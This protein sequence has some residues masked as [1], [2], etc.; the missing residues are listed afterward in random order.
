MEKNRNGKNIKDVLTSIKDKYIG[1]V[2]I[3]SGKLDYVSE[4]NMT[5][6]AWAKE[7]FDGVASDFGKASSRDASSIQI[8]NANAGKIESLRIYGNSVQDGTPS[9]DAP[10]EIQSIGD[11]VTE[12]EYKGKYKIPI[13][14]S[15]KNLF[16]QNLFNTDVGV[17][18]VYVTYEIPNGTYVMSTDFSGY[19]YANVF[20]FAG[21]VNSGISTLDNGV[22]SDTPRKIVVSDGHFTV[23]YR[24][25][26]TEGDHN[27]KKF[28]WQLEKGAIA[29]TYE[30]YVDPTIKNI[31]LDEPLRKLGE[32]ADY[33][34]FKNKRV[35]RNIKELNFTGNEEWSYTSGFKAFKLL[36]S[37]FVAQQI[38]I[39]NRF[40]GI[41]S[42][43]LENDNSVLINND[44]IY[45]TNWSLNG[46]LE[47]YKN[48][49]K[50]NKVNVINA[51]REPVEE[52]I[53]IPDILTN[54]GT[55]NIAVGTETTPSKIEIIYSK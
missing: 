16:D 24:T 48:F 36:S 17:N 29:T 5:E 32:Y 54:R 34:D 37:E 3:Q 14:V 27:P 12:G 35:V 8:D 38:P 39:S 21:T 19:H 13:T 26:N 15:G 41:T 9:I 28:N 4:E 10:A 22:T 51:L 40:K 43:V 25:A 45:V 18:A 52:K 2:E 20:I 47:K 49:L 31:Y 53:K 50:E 33:I 1:K 6:Y 7:A 55:N 42:G 23:A 46:D 11:L 44:S 30:P